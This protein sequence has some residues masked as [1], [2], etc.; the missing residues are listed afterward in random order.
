[1]LLY[2]TSDEQRNHITA[3]S[4]VQPGSYR[5][6]CIA[7]AFQRTW[8]RSCYSTVYQTNRENTLPRRTPSP[9]TSLTG[10]LC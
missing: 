7:M 5:I 9:R 2:T 3:E 8:M 6:N 1:M 10:S 4:T